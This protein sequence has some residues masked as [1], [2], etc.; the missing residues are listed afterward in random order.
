MEKGG[1]VFVGT[2]KWR[3]ASH[4][5]LQLALYLWCQDYLI[6]TLFG[7]SKLEIMREGANKDE[8]GIFRGRPYP[9]INSPLIRQTCWSGAIRKQ[10]SWVVHGLLCSLLQLRFLIRTEHLQVSLSSSGSRDTPAINHAR[11]A[12]DWRA[13]RK[14]GIKNTVRKYVDRTCRLWFW[15]NSMIVG[16]GLSSSTIE[17]RVYLYVASLQEPNKKTFEW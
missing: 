15:E 13:L 6:T 10:H 2:W 3:Y 11:T 5:V 12:T 1:N 4:C 14:S 9:Q 17:N 8:T 16:C 7:T